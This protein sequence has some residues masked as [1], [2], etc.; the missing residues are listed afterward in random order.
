MSV[1]SLTL[2]ESSVVLSDLGNGQVSIADR[3]YGEVAIDGPMRKFPL[4]EESYCSGP[5]YVS[6]LSDVDTSSTVPV[7]ARGGIKHWH[8][9]QKWDLGYFATDPVGR[10][11]VSI[12]PDKS[13]TCVEIPLA[14]FIQQLKMSER[15]DDTRPAYLRGWRFEE[16]ASLFSRFC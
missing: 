16:Y 15:D 12:L 13:D 6:K 14:S 11:H 10:A 7:V 1:S 8:G 5:T 4:N 2:F 3:H 9:Y